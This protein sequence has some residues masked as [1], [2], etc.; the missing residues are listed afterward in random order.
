MQHRHSVIAATFA[1]LLLTGCGS[2][3]RPS[4]LA[5]PTAMAA[6]E[7]CSSVF[8]SGF[9]PDVAYRAAVAPQLGPAAPLLRR[10]VDYS[11]GSVTTS[12]A[13]L[14]SRRA[15]FH[16]PLGCIVDQG[17]SPPEVEPVQAAPVV[18]TTVSLDPRFDAAL[19]QAFLETPGGPRRRTYA[20]VI[21]H[22]GRVVAERYAAGVTAD[23]RLHGWS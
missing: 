5:V 8:I 20:A 11:E 10:R 16:G 19:D 7:I 13:G 21:L 4:A 15:E 22:D 1:A 12:L 9:D 18:R 6:H 2:L 17:Q 23:T 14:A 3:E